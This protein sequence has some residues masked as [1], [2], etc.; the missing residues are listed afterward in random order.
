MVSHGSTEKKAQR[1]V[2]SGGWLVNERE[3]T[4][5]ETLRLDA[6][7]FLKMKRDEMMSFQNS[8]QRIRICDVGLASSGKKND[9][10]PISKGE[11]LATPEIRQ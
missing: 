3:K 4:R 7:H 9:R 8:G 5:D 6:M 2:L 1:L 10:A 11:M